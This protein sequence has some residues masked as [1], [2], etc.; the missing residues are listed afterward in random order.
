MA[1]QVIGICQEVSP[2][3]PSVCE[4]I[5]ANNEVFCEAVS[6][7]EPSLCESSLFLNKWQ[8]YPM[9]WSGQYLKWNDQV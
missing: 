5:A 7:T 4:E 2:G 6:P 3:T 9:D 8:D 1:I